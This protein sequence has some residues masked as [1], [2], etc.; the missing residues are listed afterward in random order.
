MIF[1]TVGTQLPFDR[2][3]KAVDEVAPILG[4]EEIIAQTKGGDY[5][6]Q[7]IKCYDYIEREQYMKLF[8][9]ARLVIS[10][11]GIGSILN[12]M[13]Y[14]KNIIIMPRQAS[15]HEH[16]N[17]HQVHTAEAIAQYEN[18]KVVNKKDEL[19]KFLINGVWFEVN[20]KRLGDLNNLAI[21]IEKFLIGS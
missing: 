21:S 11:A 20:N 5:V 1:V 6:A 3:I 7:N 16:R 9:S 15:L 4:D 14:H 12:A 17:D 8:D 10:H 2:L 19:G 13:K 18:I